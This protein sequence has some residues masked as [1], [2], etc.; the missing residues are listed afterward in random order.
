MLRFFYQ[1]RYRRAQRAGAFQIPDPSDTRHQRQ[2]NFSNY[3]TQSSVRGRQF[4]RFELPRRGKQ[5]LRWLVVGMILLFI[6]WLVCESV[7]ALALFTR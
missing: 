5:G 3:L 6:G 7:A 1:W 2:S 4:A